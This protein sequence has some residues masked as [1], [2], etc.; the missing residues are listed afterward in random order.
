MVGMA[1]ELEG[2]RVLVTGASSGIGEATARELA[3]RGARVA[4]MARTKEKVEDLAR[5]IG[6][7]ALAADVGDEQAACRAVDEAAEG[8]GG[9]DAVANIAGVQLLAPFSDGRYEEWR[10][11]LDTNVFGL[12]VVTHAALRYLRE[13]GGGD[14]VNMGSIAGRRVT[15]SDGAVYSGTKF[16]VH[17]IS[18]AIRRELHGEN[19]RVMVISPGWVNTNL[20]KDMADEEIRENLQRRQE[21]IGLAPEDVARQISRALAEPRHIML[22]EVAVMSIEED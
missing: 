19:I 16:A 8:L 21:E 3:R 13:A 1:D 2:R 18:E 22:H 12:L 17:A 15:G 5:E 11:L 14:I 20:G 9:L 7:V 6:G 4:C 10:R